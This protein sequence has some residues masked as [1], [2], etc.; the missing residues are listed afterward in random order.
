M[1]E[2]ELASIN[3]EDIDTLLNSL[4]GNTV[5]PAAE[6]PTDTSPPPTEQV[7]QPPTGG[8]E[9]QPTEGIR[10]MGQ[11]YQDRAD[12]GEPVTRPGVGGFIQ[13]TLEGTARSSFYNAAPLVG[14]LDTGIDTLN[15]LVDPEGVIPGNGI[16]KIPKYESDVSQGLRN[17]GGLVIPS[18]GL[19]GMLLKAGTKI[20]ASKTAAPW[21][22][23]LGNRTS[24]QYF[25]K[26][27][28]D[29]GTSAFVDYVAQQN[30]E[31]DTLAGTLQ[32]FWPKLFQWLP[33]GIVTTGDDS[34]GDK[35]AK[36]V[37]EGAVF[38]LIGSII[39][40][41][42]HLIKAG[43][44]MSRTARFT[45]VKNSKVTN[46]TLKELTEDE[47][48][49]VKV[50][51]EI[52][53]NQ[54][55]VNWQRTEKSLNELNEFYLE[56]GLAPKD[57]SLFDETEKLVRNP[58]ADGVPG[59]IADQAQIYGS[60]FMDTDSSWG[61]LGTP[62]SEAAR[63]RG[64]KLEN[65]SQGTL[66][67]EITKALKQAPPGSFTKTL[68]SGKTLSSNLMK[69]ASDHIAATLL[70]PRVTP[71]DIIGV[72]DEFKKAVEGSPIRIAGTKGINKAVKALKDQMLDLDVHKARAYLATS[73]AGQ[74]ADF[75]E[76]ARL[77]EDNLSVLRTIDLMSDRLEVLM[78]EKGLAKFEAGSMLSNMKTW[79]QAVDTGDQRLMTVAAEAILDSKNSRVLELIPNVKQWTQTI[80]EVAR[81]NP[82]FL[83]PLLL[84]NEFTDGNVDS[85]HK[86]HNWAQN[87]LGVFKKAIYD[88]NPEVP[89]IIN[90]A[91][92]G[93]IFNSWLSAIG[94]PLRAG[95]GNLTGLLGKGAATVTGAVLE[96]DLTAARQGMVAHF[97]LDD[98]LQKSFDHMRLVFRKASNNPKEVSYVMRS[99]IAIKQ[100]NALESLRAYADAASENGEDGA[101]ML[102][103][104]FED[105]EAMAMDPALRFGSNAMTAL[106]GF[107]KS[108]VANTEAKYIAL[109]KL[110]QSG[111]EI[112]DES[113]F[114]IS[115]E[116]YKGWFDDNDMLSNKAVESITSE[117]ALNAESPI[118]DGLNQFIKR[119]PAARAF[120]PFPK[121]TANVIETF[122]RWS[123]AGVFASDYQKLW[124][125]LGRKKLSEFSNEEIVS[126]L[127]SKGRPI[128]E[129]AQQT[130]ERIRYETKGKAAISSMFLTA[131]GF[132]AINDRCTG[133]GH[134]NKAIQRQRLRS[135][136]KAK[137][138][139]IPGTNKVG[140]YEWM[141][142][143][144]DWLALTV[145]V[146]DNFDSLST[147]MQEDIREKL[148]FLLASSITNRSM[149]S[150][151]EP[152]HDILQGNGAAASRFASSFGNALVPLGG[153]RNEFGKLLFPGLRQIRAE[154]SDNFRNRN[155]WL[156]AVDPSR[157]LPYMVDPID[158]KEV[159]KEDNWFAR[160][161][162]IGPMK[163]HEKPSKERQFLIDIEFN[164]SPMMRVSQRGAELEN[165]EITA[166]NTKMGEQGYYKK[167]IKEIMKIANNLTYGEYKG[168]VNIIQAQRR[169]LIPSDILDTAEYANIYARL[170]QAYSQ[171]KVYAENNLDDPIRS[172]IREREYEIV[173]S[174]Y[175][176]KTGNLDQVYQDAGLQ[177][178]LNMYK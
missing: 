107:A 33:D 10:S 50:S 116:V 16:P 125:P 112:T 85:M 177:E 55:I 167:R 86:L 1:E 137:T 106:D 123:P 57:W 114:K 9:Q 20:H 51:E 162:N 3:I 145:D 72:L 158:G 43:Q 143:I 96:G 105:L 58:D 111:D 46:K 133:T 134:Y 52:L 38:G 76:G 23:N 61:R 146:V 77:M 101:K 141:G 32:K 156:D 66:V 142:P 13:D 131:A 149:L 152:L 126:F 93:N 18:L 15:W 113:I 22:L 64:I 110:V 108:V 95:A 70:H 159:G 164:S 41:A 45:P 25:S 89:S 54:A 82:A 83:K 73:E 53:E 139:R 168:F 78:V 12:A 118:V 150:Q 138:C 11:V 124:G 140:S 136:W 37:N 170:K 147:G 171:A 80:K 49:N 4:E 127:K 98:T 74:V 17:L 160:V 71:D 8:Q 88:G 161:A 119:F 59:M 14:V 24:F 6:V 157:A 135:G 47:F 132:A 104:V 100:E 153:A 60:R 154:L 21:L 69:E 169:G 67:Q 175:N 28:A 174:K 176:Q 148:M 130:F 26:V 27:G 62:I 29:I 109:N 2:T 129:F 42:S 94:T 7:Q 99:D 19:R 56:E 144:G 172:G 92:W 91:M 178:T 31:N 48:T 30:A 84:A 87:N 63:K 121:T 128:D 122:G 173:N 68:R 75:A 81:E 44:S 34:A 103:G 102:L 117:I 155:A 120:M 79:R 90:K 115:D 97:A 65:L 35:R 5:Q 165:H 36:N 166:I 151:L 40:A 163:F 39:E